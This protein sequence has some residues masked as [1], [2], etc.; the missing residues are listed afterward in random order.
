MQFPH[1]SKS[2]VSKNVIFLTQVATPKIEEASL[3]RE[4]VDRSSSLSVASV[5]LLAVL[6][7]T[8][9]T[10]KTVHS[11]LLVIGSF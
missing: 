3:I 1:Y 4:E 7:Q 10:S 6:E 5:K 9:I 11:Y 2:L 8:L